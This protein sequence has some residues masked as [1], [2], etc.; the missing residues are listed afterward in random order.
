MKNSLAEELAGKIHA[1]A[2]SALTPVE[3]AGA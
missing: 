1:L 3:R 2:L